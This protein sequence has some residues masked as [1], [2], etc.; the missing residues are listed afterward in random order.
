[1]T[2]LNILF[3]FIEILNN[4]DCHCIAQGV[5]QNEKYEAINRANYYRQQIAKGLVK[6]QPKAKSMPTVVCF[7]Y[8]YVL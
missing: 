6:G 3:A 4:Y 5:T 1:M 2:T 7:Y 8:Y